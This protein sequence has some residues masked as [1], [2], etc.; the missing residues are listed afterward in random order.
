MIERKSKPRVPPSPASPRLVVGIGASAGGLAALQ[1]LLGGLAEPCDAAFIFVQHLDPER[2]NLLEQLLKQSTRLRVTELSG[3]TKLAA[4][5]L[6]IAPGNSLLELNKGMVRVSAPSI[7]SR[8]IAPIDHFLHSLADDQKSRAVGV[9]LSGSGTDGTTGLKAISD[10]GGLTFAQDPDDAR[11]DSMPRSAATSGVADHVLA[12]ADIGAEL[13]R[14]ARHLVTVTG[15]AA[16]ARLQQDLQDAIPTVAEV[17]LQETRHN[18]QHYKTSTLSRRIQRRMQVLKLAAVD[19][20]VAVLRKRPEEVQALFRDLLIGVTEFF[21]DGEAFESLAEHVL[22]EIFGSRSINDTVRIWVPGCASGQ[23]AYSI[24][25]LCREFMDRTDAQRPV[26]IFAT[27]IDDNALQTARRGVYPAGIQSEVSPERLQRYFTRRGSRYHINPDVR[28][29]VLFSPHNLISDPPLSR[30]DLIS[31]RNVLIYLGPHLQKKLIPL[32][33]Y[34][35]RPNGYLF[36]GPSENICSHRELFRAIDAKQRISQRKG[37]AVRATTAVRNAE[38]P[39]PNLQSLAPAPTDSADLTLLAQRIVLDEFAPKSVV[40]DEDGH[41]LCASADMHKYLVVGAGVFQNNLVS[42]ARSGL[43]LPV[44]AALKESLATRRRI[45]HEGASVGVGDEVQRVMVTVQPMPEMGEDAGLF[46][47]VFQDVGLPKSR[48]ER[49]AKAGKQS[50][51]TADAELLIQQLEQELSAARTELERSLQEMEVGNE[52]LKSSNEELLSMNEELQSANEELETSKEEIEAGS[53][54]L[55]QV[56]SH[57]ENLLRST[58]IAT[59]FLDDDLNVRGFTPAATELYGLIDTDIGRPLAQLMP[60]ADHMPAMPDPQD[61]PDE[62]SIAHLTHTRSG[63]IFIRRV[64]PYRAADGRRDG[65]VVT[66]SDVTAL[67]ES[68]RQLQALIDNVPVMI[69]YIDADERYRFVSE[70][71]AEEFKRPRD[72]IVGERVADVLGASNFRTMAPHIRQALAGE[73]ARYEFELRIEQTQKTSYKVASYIP[74]RGVDGRVRGCYAVIVD[75]TERRRWERGLE[76]REAHLRR[77]IDNTLAFIGVLDTDGTLVEANR[78]ALVAAGIERDEVIG[79]KFWDCY[80]WSHDAGVAARLRLAIATAATGEIVRYD[81]PVRLAAGAIVHIDFMLVP[82]RDAEGVVTHLIPSGVDISARLAAQRDRKEYAERLKLAMRSAKM[83]SFDWNPAT[84]ESVWDDELH[85][86]LGMSGAAP[87]SATFFEMIHPDDVEAVRNAID[88]ALAEGSDYHARFRIRRPDGEVR[89]L[90]GHGTIIPAAGG[91]PLRMVGLNWDITAERDTA[92]KL[93]AAEERMRMASDAAGFGTYYYDLERGEIQWSGKLM[94][95]IGAADHQA[96]RPRPGE[97]PEFVHPDDRELVAQRFA[98]ILTDA[99]NDSH[100]L[101]YRIVRPDGDVRWLRLQGKTFYTAGNGTARRPQV[102]LGTVVDITQQKHFEESLEQARRKAE[103]ANESKSAFIANMSHEIRTPMTAVLGYTQLLAAKETDPQKLEHLRTIK[104]NGSYLLDIIND[105]LDLSKIEA[106]KLDVNMELFDVH[107]LVSEVRSM[108]AMR[109][110]SKNLQFNIR[111]AGPIPER[112]RSDRK[113]LKQILTNLLGNAI[114]FTESGSVELV[115]EAVPGRAPLLRF[116]VI[117]TGVGISAE[118]Q[119]QLFQP[120][121]QGDA[122]VARRFGGTGLGLDIS[123]RL[124]RSLGGDISVQSE[125]GKGSVF[126]CTIGLEDDAPLVH[127]DPRFEAT[128]EFEGVIGERP[129]LACRVLVV[130]DHDDVRELARRFLSEAGATVEVSVDGCDALRRIEAGL[131]NAAPQIDLVLLDMHM[132]QL[133]G[134]AAARKMR[135]RGFGRPIIAVT[136][137]AMHGDMIRCIESGC[138]AYLSKPIDRSELLAV[139]AQYAAIVDAIELERRRQ[140]YL[141]RSQDGAEEA[142]PA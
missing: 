22:P 34:A 37:T 35:L 119:A 54:A 66:F 51:S 117:D 85:A 138:D 88:K 105:I 116:D 100:S 53:E 19:D 75:L 6:Y 67:E 15:A 108:M 69:A 142:A 38:S 120:F 125:P 4:N 49:A 97:V 24:A 42:M 122:S 9:I 83:G 28:E 68:K 58:A 131:D 73:V 124:A 104:R 1:A 46:L 140:K 64:L 82:V 45:V 109:A 55:A 63:K 107:E 96:S 25:I 61:V 110:T 20:Y 12:A 111:Y 114:K 135:A 10:A 41:V 81:V 78:T 39:P 36:L 86:L 16:T 50:D 92:E 139:V 133:D 112:M 141:Q 70:Q 2:D 137:E 71:Y 13:A 48:G 118:H 43:R 132:P 103:Q 7:E 94:E 77:V 62:G 32:F 127:I 123:R 31:C 60:L 23:E 47:V 17:L 59:I 14:Y 56:N 95:I 29:L 5:T 128:G 91:K 27:D 79:K 11:F 8:V 101:T 30:Q 99:A 80:W 57:L 134:R 126:S 18:F 106:G 121:A 115:V 93:Q 44:R 74:D 21:R 98:E 33:H 26:R 90:A 84:D 87:S 136:A 3:R 52:E 102:V 89:W 40:V 76:D 72:S 129:P 113:R 130:D 65:L